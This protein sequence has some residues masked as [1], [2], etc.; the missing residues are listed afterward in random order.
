ME[1]A[2]VVAEKIVETGKVE[3]FLERAAFVTAPQQIGALLGEMTDRVGEVGR[4]TSSDADKMIET[5]A[6][7]EVHANVRNWLDSDRTDE[8][9]VHA[10]VTYLIAHRFWTTR[11]TS[12]SSQWIEQIKVEVKGDLVDALGLKLA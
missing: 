11:S 10:I 6:K 2:K 7:D 1:I 8:E 9:K 3:D 12:Y 4:L 5:I